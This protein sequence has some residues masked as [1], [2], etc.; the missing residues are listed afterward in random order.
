MIK[1]IGKIVFK[2]TFSKAVA[3][4]AAGT[5]AAAGAG[6][7]GVAVHKANAAIDKKN[8]EDVKNADD[9]RKQKAMDDALARLQKTT[10]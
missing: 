3:Y 8:L 4:A 5:L 10:S 2:V 7:V 1:L 9:M 6:A